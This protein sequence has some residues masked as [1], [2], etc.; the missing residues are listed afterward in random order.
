MATNF[1][2]PLS[3]FENGEVKQM[4]PPLLKVRI[5]VA[6]P[7]P[8]ADS[9]F[10]SGTILP[11]SKPLFSGISIWAK[12]Q[13]ALLSRSR[14]GL[15]SSLRRARAAFEKNMPRYS[16]CSCDKGRRRFGSCAF[17]K[18][19]YYRPLWKGR[20]RTY[21]G[22]E[23][24]CAKGKKKPHAHLQCHPRPALPFP[25]A[26]THAVRPGPFIMSLH[27][28]GTDEPP[29]VL[30]SRRHGRS[31]FVIAVDH[32]SRRIPKRLATLGLAE[33]DLGRHIA[34][35]IGALAVAQSVSA[36]LDAPQIGR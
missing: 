22:R 31:A 34:W 23:R 10:S 35:D 17:F 3:Q 15:A 13:P 19:L 36:A 28:L 6:M 16:P 11:Q 27:L 32:A 33:S 24:I 1:G 25:Q 18:G 5:R 4:L 9:P 21:R 30:A 29:P 7:L 8:E 20:Q 14:I 26:R 12:R 2:K